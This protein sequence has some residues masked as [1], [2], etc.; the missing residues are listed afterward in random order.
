MFDRLEEFVETA[1]NLGW[2]VDN[3]DAQ[4]RGIP[5]LAQKTC[6]MWGTLFRGG[7]LPCPDNLAPRLRESYLRGTAPVEATAPG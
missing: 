7:S 4:R 2:E 3:L 6:E 5:H 1:T